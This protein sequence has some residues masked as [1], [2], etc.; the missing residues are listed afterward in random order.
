M[1]LKLI[2]DACQAHG[3]EFA[4]HRAGSVGDAAAFSFY[5]SKNLGAYGEGGLITT[6]DDDLA[7]RAR[8]IR[9]HGS[10]KRYYHDLLGLTPAWMRSRRWCCARS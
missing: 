10:G 3:A 9:D 1:G 6:N 5:F 2:E 7:Q 4:G 8:M